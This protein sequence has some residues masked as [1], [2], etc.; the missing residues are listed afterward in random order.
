M[1]D[2][3]SSINLAENTRN[4]ALRKQIEIAFQLTREHLIRKTFTLLYV[5]SNDNTADCMT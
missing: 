3:T 4:I 1:A 2:N 5:P